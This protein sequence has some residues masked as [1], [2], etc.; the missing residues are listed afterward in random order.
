MIFFLPKDLIH[1][2]NLN[3]VKHNSLINCPQMFHLIKIFTKDENENIIWDRTF[4]ILQKSGKEFSSLFRIKTRC[5]GRLGRCSESSVLLLQSS[6]LSLVQ[7]Q[8]GFALIGWIL[9]TVMLHQ[10][11]YAIKAQLKGISCISLCHYGIR[12]RKDLL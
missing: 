2:I 1:S 12:N 9:I 10:L 8:R 4:Y 6:P 3:L 7:V 11:S 5:V